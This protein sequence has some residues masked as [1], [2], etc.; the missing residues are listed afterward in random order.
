MPEMHFAVCWPDG[1]RTTHYSPSLVM[2]DFLATG[3][4]Y[5]VTDFVT[6]TS[7]GLDAASERVR[8]K[9]G[10]A[11]TSAMASEA[12]IAEVAAAYSDGEVT[13]LSMEPQLPGGAR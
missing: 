6:R 2:H 3:L 12:E 4:T 1:V 11:C 13:V 5:S 7:A 10:M 8:A 9:Y